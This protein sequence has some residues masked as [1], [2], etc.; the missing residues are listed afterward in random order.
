MV[1][2]KDWSHIWSLR[3]SKLKFNGSTVLE[4]YGPDLGLVAIP[5]RYLQALYSPDLMGQAST[6]AGRQE[7]GWSLDYERDGFLVSPS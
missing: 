7:Y 6:S 5:I 1:P 2:S 3:A 4:L